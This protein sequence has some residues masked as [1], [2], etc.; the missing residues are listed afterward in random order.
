[1]T[2]Y[3]TME[4]ITL[5]R[6]VTQT[7][8]FFVTGQWLVV[9]FLRCP[10]GVPFV[11]CA[12]CPL[13]DCWGQFLHL[14]VYAGLALSLV[15]V[16]RAFCGWACPLGYLQDLVGRFAPKAVRK[17]TL[18]VRLDGPLRLLKYA[19]L[20][21]V[22]W[23]AFTLNVAPDRGHPYVVRSSSVLN[24]DALRVACGLGL[25]R[26]PVR[27]A[28]LVFALLSALV[29]PRAWCRYVCP[30]GALLGLLSRISFLRLTRDKAICSDC[31][32]FPQACDTGTTP[33]TL[34]CTVCGDCTQA[35]PSKAI[36][37]TKRLKV[38]PSLSIQDAD[39]SDAR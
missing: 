2:Q 5:Q 4:R 10:F 33:G 25:Q 18:F 9:G 30:L 37:L 1:M 23:W 36:R 15:S 39:S 16:G 28:L 22:I 35:C 7:I 20:I 34:E 3:K 6:R 24:P 26:Y 21:L 38:V 8:F 27:A 13:G 31:G 32:R 11:S 17:A 12:G 19:A 14:S 29:V